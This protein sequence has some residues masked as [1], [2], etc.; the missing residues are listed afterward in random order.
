MTAVFLACAAGGVLASTKLRKRVLELELLIGAIGMFSTEIRYSAAPLDAI[1]DKIDRSEDYR[2]LKIFSLCRSLF[3]KNRDF[4][5]AWESAIKESKQYLS[6]N[7]NDYE[8][9]VWFGRELGATDIEGQMANCGRCIELLTQRLEHAR[10]EQKKRGK[11]YTSLG[12]LTG[13]F[14]VVLFL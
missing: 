12:F 11:M 2:R 6:L 1:L 14:F 7:K 4:T 5:K 3:L 13:M 9:L 8:A 10:D